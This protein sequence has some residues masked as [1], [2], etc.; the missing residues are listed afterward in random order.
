MPSKRPTK[1][2]R[3]ATIRKLVSNL[4][5][6]VVQLQLEQDVVELAKQLKS[7]P[8]RLRP[9]TDAE[10]KSMSIEQQ[11]G[12]LAD[13]FM[14]LRAEEYGYAEA[15]RKEGERGGSRFRDWLDSPVVEVVNLTA[16]L[17]TL[18]GAAIAGGWEAMRLL[19]L[20]AGPADEPP[21]VDVRYIID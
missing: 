10:W 1:G 4:Q 6:E 7:N 15:L 14:T 21:E 5:D 13:R 8:Q 3:L 2:D 18:G 12:R 19:G 16:S 9:I 20:G 11:R 17:L